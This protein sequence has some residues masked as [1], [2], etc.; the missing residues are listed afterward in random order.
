MDETLQPICEVWVRFQQEGWHCWPDAPDNVSYLRDSH[1]HMFWYEVRVGVGRTEYDRGIEF[2]TLL[3]FCR[4]QAQGPNLGA[5]S[6]EMLALAM[7][8]I[9]QA[10]CNDVD[11]QHFPCWRTVTVT[12]SEDNECGATVTV[13]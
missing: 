6:C 8:E 5:N 12:V 7:A 4:E 3:K 13:M 2:H 9:V 1:R 11:T 10:W